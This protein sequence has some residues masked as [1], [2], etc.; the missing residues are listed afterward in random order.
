M[1][2][3]GIIIDKNVTFNKKYQMYYICVMN[4]VTF[5]VILK[6]NRLGFLLICL[7]RLGT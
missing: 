6:T 1:E 3:R 2:G 4:F 5:S 7:A